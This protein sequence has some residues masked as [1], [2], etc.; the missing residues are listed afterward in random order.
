M[1]TDVDMMIALDALIAWLVCLG[2]QIMTVVGV[3]SVN[4]ANNCH[5]SGA[6][7]RYTLV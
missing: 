3:A 5:H 1:L 2:S 7:K 4:L 6:A